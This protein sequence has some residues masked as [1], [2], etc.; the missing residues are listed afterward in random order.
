MAAAATESPTNATR[1]AYTV[2]PPTA[3]VVAPGNC[4][5]GEEFASAPLIDKIPLSHDTAVLTFG[6]PG[7]ASLGLST[8]AC[9]LAKGG[10]DEEGNPM[11]RPYTPVSTNVMTGKFELMVKVG[12]GAV[13]WV[14]QSIFFFGGGRSG[15]GF[16]VFDCWS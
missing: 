10:V 12:G 1:R 13:G 4:V 14:W 6:V 11:V 3:A 9:L 7:E 5:F 8:C 15:G 2:G 16:Y